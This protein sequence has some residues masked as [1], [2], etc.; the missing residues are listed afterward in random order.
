MD[1]LG[2]RRPDRGHAPRHRVHRADARADRRARRQRSRLRGRRPGRLLRRRVAS[3][4]TARCRTARSTSC[5]SRRGPA[6]TSTSA[7]RSPVD[8]ALW[9]AAKPGE[10]AWD[11]PWGPGRPGWH[12]E[13]S[14]MSLGSPRRGLRP[15]RWRATTSSSPTTRT[16]GPRPKPPAMRSPATGCTA[17]WSRS[18]A[19]RCRSRSATSPRSP[20]RSTPTARRAFRLAVLQTHYRRADRARSDAE[21][22][23][24]GEARRPARCAGP[25]RGG[26]RGRVDAA[27]PDAAIGRAVPRRRWTTTSHTPAAVAVIFDAVSAANAAIDDGDPDRGGRAAARRSASS[28]RSLGLPIG[29]PA[30]G[31]T[32]RS[33]RSCAAA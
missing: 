5:S 11:S 24:A 21:L 28:P 29:G 18:A 23:A 20:T 17:G 4:A 27:A 7:K 26:R 2:V 10:P 19:R 6:S 14:A 32:P 3:P 9:K 22:D 30:E 8:F 31:P 16:S 25:D 15:P 1:R 12:I 33:T 13:C